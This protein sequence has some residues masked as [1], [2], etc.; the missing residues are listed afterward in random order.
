MKFDQATSIWRSEEVGLIKQEWGRDFKGKKVLDLGC[1]EG[2]VAR[3]AMG[4]KLEW[5]LDNDQEMVR[6]AKRSGVYKKV[7]LG[8]AGKIPLKDNQVELVFSN[9]VLEHI[10][11]L[12]ETL[13]EVSRVLKKGGLLIATMPSDQLVSYL[14]WGKIY[15]WLFNK[16]YQH[17]H[18]YSVSQWTEL[19]REVGLE[20]LDSYYYLDQET[21]KRWH[22]CLWLNKLGL[23][24]DYSPKQKMK[25]QTV[26]AGIAIKA[27]RVRQ[28][29]DT[30]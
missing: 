14:A 17:Y 26:G 25:R 9:S 30:V 3:E 10:C 13:K 12:T 8:E 2:E 23:K 19:L 28:R 29:M 27:R 21:I 7:I 15:G 1:G 20:L 4:F 18:L 24:H 22:R 6:K 11:H 5:G 16:K